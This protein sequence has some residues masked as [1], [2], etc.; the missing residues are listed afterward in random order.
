MKPKVRCL[1]TYPDLTPIDPSNTYSNPTLSFYGAS[2]SPPATAT[3]VCFMLYLLQQ[4]VLSTQQH[5][6][7]S[8]SIQQHPTASNST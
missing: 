1:Y 8:N 6:I 7:A 2:Y 4:T 3:A 5:P